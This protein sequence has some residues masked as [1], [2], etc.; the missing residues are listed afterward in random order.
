MMVGGALLTICT[1]VCSFVKQVPKG[2]DAAVKRRSGPR[3]GACERSDLES[4][5]KDRPVLVLKRRGR[6]QQWCNFVCHYLSSRLAIGILIIT[7]LVL[8][9]SF[10]SNENVLAGR[11]SQAGE[12]LLNVNAKSSASTG[13]GS[14]TGDGHS[15][16]LV[17]SFHAGYGSRAGDEALDFG[18]NDVLAG[19]GSR[20]GEELISDLDFPPLLLPGVLMNLTR[21]MR[22]VTPQQHQ[23]II[24]TDIVWSGCATYSVVHP[25]RVVVSVGSLK[26]PAMVDTGS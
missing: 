9:A 7:I 26:I 13:F 22:P 23:Q 14:Q 2:A 8:M 4:T 1:G 25:L 17:D 24:Q 18:E 21:V 16:E 5:F 6:L 3:G 10:W 11:G 20:I 15:S 19:Y 12:E